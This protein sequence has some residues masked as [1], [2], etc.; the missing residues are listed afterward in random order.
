[1]SVNGWNSIDIKNSEIQ[2]YLKFSQFFFYLIQIA[3]YSDA[4]KEHNL[5]V[6][7]TPCYKYYAENECPHSTTA[8][9]LSTST[10]LNLS[11]K[12]YDSVHS[13]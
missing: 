13:C 9:K 11:W 4:A 10:S 8:C 3:V 1:M 5:F 2:Y 12:F 7:Q 6:R